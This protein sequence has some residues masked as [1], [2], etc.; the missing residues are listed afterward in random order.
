MTLNNM[1]HLYY[2][3]LLA[4]YQLGYRYSETEAGN[5]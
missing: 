5:V 1:K 2:N 3:L 4:S